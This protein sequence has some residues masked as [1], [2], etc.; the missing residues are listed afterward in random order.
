MLIIL[1]S[2]IKLDGDLGDLLRVGNLHTTIRY[3][4]TLSL[5]LYIDVYIDI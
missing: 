2:M 4:T 1:L 5:S 3:D